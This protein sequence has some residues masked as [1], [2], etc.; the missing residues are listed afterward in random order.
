MNLWV[1]RV[2]QLAV[3]A[4]ALFFFSCEDETSLLGYKN[5]SSKFKL[6]YVDIPIGSSVLLFDSVRTSNNNAS[7]DLNRFLVGSYT[8]PVF[9]K[10]T[11][12]TFAQFVPLGQV[13]KN[14][15]IT[16]VYDSVSLLLRFDF[17]AYGAAGETTQTFQ[18]Y[19]LDEL[20]PFSNSVTVPSTIGGQHTPTNTTLNSQK[21]YYSN[22]STGYTTLLGDTTHLVNMDK[23]NLYIKDRDPKTEFINLPLDL[24]FGKD[25]FDLALVGDSTFTRP[26]LFTTKF[27]GL[28]FAPGASS[29]KI[30][31]LYPNDDTTR[32]RIHYHSVRNKNNS[33]KDTLTLEFAF[34]RMS[35]NKIIS[36]RSGTT[37]AD[38]TNTYEDYAPTD[39]RYIQAGSGIVTKLDLSKFMDF[40]HS[41]SITRMAINS[42]ELVI[43]N[44]DAPGVFLPPQNLVVRILE[45]NNRIKKI[46][47]P[48]QGT[49]YSKDFADLSLYQGRVTF[50]QSSTSTYHG[51]AFDSTFT[52]VNDQGAF[53]TLGYSTEQNRYSGTASLFFQQLFRRKDDET[54]FTKVVLMP[55]EV[56]TAS[57]PFG[58]HLFGKS[59]NRVSFDQNNIVLRVYYTIPT[60]NQN[61]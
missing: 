43:T 39:K 29:D 1:K 31:G 8:D 61:Q 21:L 26:D 58:R 28:A 12:T 33:V 17:Y 48:S 13:P 25:I 5:P 45:D 9:G 55:L 6:G 53:F 19:K 30:V 7:N 36:D 57:A 50:D 41:D 14:D 27:F 2:G 42:A 23:F 32:L 16:Y 49:A 60:V 37:L 22:S 35:Y 38:L 52:V 3:V 56:P 59:L 4:V 20:I 46:S 18:I 54:L 15:S 40:A 34:T 24:N 44:V 51:T 11:A 10:A 47:P